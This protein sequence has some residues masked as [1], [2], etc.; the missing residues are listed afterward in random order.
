MRFSL[1]S[2]LSVLAATGASRALAPTTTSTTPL[3]LNPDPSVLQNVS[4]SNLSA[5]APRP[6]PA[7]VYMTNGKRLS[8]GLPLNPPSH[9]NKRA[10]RPK[11]SGVPPVS[12]SGYIQVADAA[13][14]TLA[15]YLTTELNI[16]GEYGYTSTNV[17]EALQVSFSYDP[18]SPGGIE[19]TAANGLDAAAPLFGF[20]VGYASISGDLAVESY[21]Y[22]YLGGVI[23][24]SAGVPPTSGVSS[25]KDLTQISEDV[26]SSI[27]EYDPSTQLL[28]PNWINADSTASPSALVYIGSDLAP[29]FAITGDVAEFNSTFGV[30]ADSVTFKLVAAASAV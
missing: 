3:Q 10:H 9:K 22:N 24:T 7:P 16:F 17:T 23:H 19:I 12:V 30:S 25:F 20:I 11:P 28:A 21:N 29:F 18:T 1:A 6:A 13:N 15:G 4:S 2:L 26:E 14:S 27:W 5:R 8:L